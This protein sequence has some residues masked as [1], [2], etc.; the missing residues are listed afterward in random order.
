MSW[1]QPLALWRNV[2]AR[3]CG[4]LEDLPPS[5][6][7]I[8]R[9]FAKPGAKPGVASPRKKR[10]V[11]SAIEEIA[12]DPSAREEY[13]SGFHKRKLQRMKYAKEEAAKKD[14]E[15]KLTARKIVRLAVSDG[16]IVPK[17]NAI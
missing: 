13:L 15:E 14:R 10:M 17:K 1:K 11:V 6:S 12:F 5:T 3:H 4:R 9:M 16:V 8:H 2:V 7:L